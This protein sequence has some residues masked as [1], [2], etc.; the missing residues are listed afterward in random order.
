MN[1]PITINQSLF[2]TSYFRYERRDTACPTMILQQW[3][4]G[5]QEAR[6]LT[7]PEYCQYGEWRDVPI[8]QGK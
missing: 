8:V 4:C 1:A 5:Y 6:D 3:H 2:P 7:L